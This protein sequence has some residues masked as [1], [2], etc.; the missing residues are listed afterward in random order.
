MT[1]TEQQK[2]LTSLENAISN[3]AE[4]ISEE[5]ELWQHSWGDELSLSMAR[6]ALAVLEGAAGQETYLERE[7]GF[8][9]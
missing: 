1:N 5:G 3:W 8:K 2:L 9:N 4:E 6:A 7:R